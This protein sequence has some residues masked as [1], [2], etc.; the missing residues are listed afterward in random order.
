MGRWEHTWK[1]EVNLD[2]L[3][4]NAG[5]FVAVRRLIE[6][7]KRDAPALLIRNDLVL[8][9]IEP[10]ELDG[11]SATRLL[12]DAMLITDW[13]FQARRLAHLFMG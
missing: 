4:N 5:S 3:R 9:L 13:Y 10:L 12:D 6:E 11:V 1:R 8:T 7:T 2:W